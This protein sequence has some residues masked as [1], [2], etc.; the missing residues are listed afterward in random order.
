MTLQNRADTLANHRRFIERVIASGEVWGL[1]SSNGWAVCDSV[2]DDEGAEAEPVQGAVPLWSDRAHAQRAAQGEWEHFV[3]S[4]IPLDEFIDHWL[5]GMHEDDVLVG[6]DWDAPGCGVEIEA[7]EL[8]Q[9]LVSA[10]DH[11]AR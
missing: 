10:L 3:P 8:A 11:E 4:A 6:T 2:A 9:E 1:E 7:L 5:K